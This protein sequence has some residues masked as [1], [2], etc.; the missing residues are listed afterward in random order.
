M[1]RN[2]DKPIVRSRPV[3]PPSTDKRRWPWVEGDSWDA[4]RSGASVSEP[5][6]EESPASPAAFGQRPAN[7]QRR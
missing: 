2:R 3:L 7:Q 4:P 6:T 5:K 1:T